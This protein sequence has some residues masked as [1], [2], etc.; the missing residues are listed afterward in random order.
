MIT[1]SSCVS[2]FRKSSVARGEKK[3]YNT[4][5]LYTCAFVAL[6]LFITIYIYIFFFSTLGVNI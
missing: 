4:L 6:H 1:V 5:G 3:V 2:N